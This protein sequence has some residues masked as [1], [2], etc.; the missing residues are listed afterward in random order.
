MTGAVLALTSALFFAISS[1][2]AKNAAHRIGSVVLVTTRLVSSAIF[3][4]LIAVFMGKLELVLEVPVN[5][6]LLLVAS[7]VIMVTGHLM[8]VKAMALDDVTRV[9][10]ATTGLYIFMSMLFSILLDIESISPQIILGGTIVLLGVY[11]L[12]TRQSP[13]TNDILPRLSFKTFILTLGT[14][15]TWAIG[16]IVMDTVVNHL[17]PVP[18]SA[19]RVC[20][21]AMIAVG[22]AAST[23]KLKVDHLS[24]FD[25]FV[26][27]SSG[28]AL[29]A[30][31]L[32]FVAALTWSTP[33]TVVIL[34]STAPFF[35][36][37]ISII[38]LR[39]KFTLK[40]AAGIIA[41]FLGIL[42]T[43]I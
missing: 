36:V 21:M 35:L 15:I 41:C 23:G 4:V 33:A 18:T 16:V 10:P 30:S 12:S 5:I 19:I 17:D 26:I 43:L 32:T 6:L 31:I 42:L 29:G 20:L 3:A 11:L 28:F 22:L 14:S 25:L 13:R 37:P 8:F 7:G 27:W 40:I 34:N 9:L 38:W 2:L 24:K 39:E 1:A